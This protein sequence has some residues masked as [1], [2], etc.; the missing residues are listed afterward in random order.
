MN[1]KIQQ[2]GLT[3]VPLKVFFNAKGLCKIELGLAKGKKD[4]DKRQDIKKREVDKKL[5]RIMKRA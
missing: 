1:S 5:R 3:V 2:K 4:H